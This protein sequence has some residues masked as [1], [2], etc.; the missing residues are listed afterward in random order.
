MGDDQK[1]HIELARDIASSFNNMFARDIQK[2][3]F[4]LPEPQILG[5]A[6]R[7]MSLRDGSK[8]MYSAVSNHM[9]IMNRK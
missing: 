3:F 1:Q 7:V 4:I 5:Q 8:K 9:E 6:T 2:E